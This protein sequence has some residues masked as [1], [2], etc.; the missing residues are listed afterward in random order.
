V[1][2]QS[3]FHSEKGVE[4]TMGNGGIQYGKSVKKREEYPKRPKNVIPKKA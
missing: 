1:N 3:K 2:S 4:I